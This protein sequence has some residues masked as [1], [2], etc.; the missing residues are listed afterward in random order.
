MTQ[1]KRKKKTNL[2]WNKFKKQQIISQEVKID[3]YKK[4]TFI[5]GMFYR[6]V[7]HFKTCVRNVNII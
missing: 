5:V 6:L 7:S 3:T 2:H 1:R 4:N